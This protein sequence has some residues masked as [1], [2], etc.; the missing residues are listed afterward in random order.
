[1][2]VAPTRFAAGIAH[3]VGQ[4][5]AF[6]VPVAATDLIASQ[7]G[8]ASGREILTASTAAAFADACASLYEDAALWAR[9][10]E[11]A[12]RRIEVDGSTAQFSE[13]VGAI[14]SEIGRGA[15]S[16]LADGWL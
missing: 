1:V 4:A 15:R 16:G 7:L 5:A 14:V 9:V 13:T 6:G 8:W 12:L 3:K 2:F 10:R 11:A